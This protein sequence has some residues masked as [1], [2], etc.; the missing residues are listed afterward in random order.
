MVTVTGLPP[1]CGDNPQEG[2][3]NTD[4]STF[5]KGAIYIGSSFYPVLSSKCSFL[6]RKNRPGNSSFSRRR[7]KKRLGIRCFC[8]KNR[9][10]ETILNYVGD[11]HYDRI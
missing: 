6:R 10:N 11:Y 7:S 3:V 1:S 9:N 5:K 8:P 2:T 4:V